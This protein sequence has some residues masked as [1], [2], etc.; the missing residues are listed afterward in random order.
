MPRTRS[1]E[2]KSVA[3]YLPNAQ[4]DT[5]SVLNRS[6]FPIGDDLGCLVSTP[7]RVG[8]MDIRQ[9]SGAQQERRLP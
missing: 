3:E 7:G 5:G 6:R 9:R 4:S 8:L 2:T 1:L